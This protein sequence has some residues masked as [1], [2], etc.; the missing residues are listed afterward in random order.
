M[1]K[2][3]EQLMETMYLMFLSSRQLNLDMDD[4]QVMWE[5]LMEKWGIQIPKGWEAFLEE[6]NCSASGSYKFF[7]VAF[8]KYFYVNPLKKV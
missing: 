1:K 8:W 4:Y 7:E 5:S 2:K 6:I 3:Y